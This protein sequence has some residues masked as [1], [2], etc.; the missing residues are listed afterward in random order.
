MSCVG[1]VKKYD[2]AKGFG[3]IVPSE[4]NGG[5]DLF[6]LRTDV[7][8]GMLVAGDQVCYDEG[9]NERNGNSKAV[10]V[11]G[12]TGGMQDSG[13][14]GDKG[15]FG[16]KGKS[17]GGSLK[18]K[19]ELNN[20]MPQGG[21]FGGGFGGGGFPGVPGACAGG[22][23]GGGFGN[24]N[25]KTGSVKFFNDSKGFGFITQDSGEPDLFV[26]RN[27]VQGQE[28][29]EGDRVQ[30]VEVQDDRSGRPKAQQVT[31]GTG[32]AMINCGKG[33]SK[34]CGGG[35][36]GKKGG[37]GKE[38]GGVMGGPLNFAG[39]A[40]QGQ[41]CAPGGGG[42]GP[43]MQAGL[44]MMPGAGMMQGG[45]GQMGQ[46][47]MTGVP[48]MNPGLGMGGYS[49][50]LPDRGGM[51]MSGMRGQGGPMFDDDFAPSQAYNAGKGFGAPGGG[52]FMQGG[53]GNC[54]QGGMLDRFGPGGSP[55]GVGMMGGQLGQG[56]QHQLG[57]LGGQNQNFGGGMQPFAMGGGSF[58]PASF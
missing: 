1:I 52:N 9:F 43:G 28:L 18:G 6:V 48:G 58:A 51:M 27:D 37:K 33:A 10:N 24:G 16:G 13:K 11:T 47:G 32:S 17:K 8:G 15:G 42:L 12:G 45:A 46:G 21:S 20:M 5:Q 14:G 2:A 31:G 29:T 23:M 19:N 22:I 49:D 55:Q 4:D 57:G 39:Y 38:P 7:I 54:M 26:H 3:F 56:G 40:P 35:G 50:G 41:G 34:G 36:K 30:F 44:G 25:T 53:G